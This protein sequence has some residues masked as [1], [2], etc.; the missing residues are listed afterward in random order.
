MLASLLALPSTS[1]AQI[2]EA[3]F[4][5]EVIPFKSLFTE[6]PQTS[7][8]ALKSSFAKDKI[9]D[10]AL[11]VGST[12]I[13]LNNDEVI[14]R[15]IQRGGRDLGYP[16]E[17]VT[18]SVLSA[19]EI[20]LIR[21]PTDFSSFTY[22]LGDG[23]MHGGIAAGFLI[24]G[25]GNKNSRAANTGLQLVHGMMVSTV[26]NQILKR[27]FGRESPYVKTED[28]GRWS[29]FPSVKEYQA[30]TS[31]YDA[32]PSGHIMTMTLAFTIINENYPEYSSVIVPVGVAW[33]TLLM[34]G[35]VNNGVHW[36]SDYPLG[37]AMGYVFGKASAQLGKKQT[38]AEKEVANNWN[39]IP[40][41]N[42]EMTGVN[43]VYRY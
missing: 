31:K 12:L 1:S 37:I 29:P 41:A 23:L 30:R 15:D 26:F 4:D 42:S 7:W 19:G 5:A 38:P 21:L 9:D 39:L 11:I 3:N 24:N 34:V 28:F 17:D 33:G 13:L 6:L 10:W 25:Y 22:F 35:M 40:V 20:D 8:T 14:L 43:F 32:M 16:N 18:K 36:A 27:S 2:P